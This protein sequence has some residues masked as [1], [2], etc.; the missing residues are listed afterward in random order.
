MCYQPKD[1]SSMYF[2]KYFGHLMWRVNSWKKPWF[3]KR[4]KT[5][6]ER[7]DRG[8][9]GSVQFSSVQSLNRV[10]LFT[11][12]WLQHS[13]PPRSSPSPG[14]YSNSCP[15][16][17]WCHPTI[18][19]HLLEFTQIHVHWVSDAIQPSHPLLSPSPHTFNP[20]QHL[21][22]FKWV[23]SLHQIGKALEFQL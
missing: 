1:S 14:V 20:S 15:L 18:S 5:G 13:S 19:S 2:S 23:S 7:G 16:S 11:T 8:W 4:L 10:Q 12:P 6:E 3:L 9:D 21:G 17:Q 22:L